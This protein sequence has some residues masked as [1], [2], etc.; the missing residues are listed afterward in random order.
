MLSESKMRARSPIHLIIS[1]ILVG[2]V[3]FESLYAYSQVP[4]IEKN[5][6]TIR[7]MEKVIESLS[8]KIAAVRTDLSEVEANIQ[9]LQEQTDELR[10]QKFRLQSE[11]DDLEK[12]PK[13]KESIRPSYDEFRKWL[14]RDE[15]NR[16]RYR[17]FA[18]DCDDFAAMLIERGEE[19]GWD[20][21]FVYIRGEGGA[22]ALCAIELE[23]R[24]LVWVEPQRDSIFEPKKVGE[25]YLS[26]FGIGKIDYILLVW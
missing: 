21:A 25:G 9:S 17:K 5:G 14:H 4:L 18:F 20:I 23:D 6:D 22:H 12:L 26:G 10:S 3:T 19:N 8:K 15:T 24:G 2:A 16:H 13:K 7:A 11:I 1:I